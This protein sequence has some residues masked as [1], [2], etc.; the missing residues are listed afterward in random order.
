MASLKKQLGAYPLTYFLQRERK[1]EGYS[2][3]EAERKE[4]FGR[5]GLY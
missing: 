1:I 2:F 5:E 4:G 3:M